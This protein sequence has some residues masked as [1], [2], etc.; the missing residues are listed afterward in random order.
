MNRYL[1]LHFL[2][3]L[4]AATAILGELISIS[5]VELVIWR[6]LIACLGAGAWLAFRRRPLWPGKRTALLLTG[7]GLIIGVHWMCFFGAVKVANISIC[8]AGLATIPLFT[9]FTEPLL[10]KRRVR[11]FEVLLG[12][13]VFAGISVVAGA[14]DTSKLPGLMLAL[15]GAFLAAVFPVL[16][17]R[18]VTTGGDPL[19]M[20]GWEMLGALI[21]ALVLLPW[22][23]SVTGLVAWRGL[24][25]LWLLS[26]ALVCTV[27]AHGLHIRLL[28]DFSAYTM[29]LAISFEPLYGILAAA[30]FFGEHKQLPLMFYAGLSTIL[31]AN[32]IH[33]MCVKRARAKA[34]A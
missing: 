5:S 6:T 24:D 20:V 22:F 10:E 3:L 14:I 28:K 12:L 13:L 23:G 25:W 7:I 32:V 9:A 34:T 27:F 8:L 19:T 15:A 18:L 2:V 31:L 11:L 21:A 16:N 26:L 29:N 4:L 1:Q 30:L 17:R 33:P